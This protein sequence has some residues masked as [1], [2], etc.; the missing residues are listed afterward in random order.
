MHRSP[1]TLLQVISFFILLVHSI[2]DKKFWLIYNACSCIETNVVFHQSSL[3]HKD[4]P[5]FD[6]LI[7]SNAFLCNVLFL[8]WLEIFAFMF[9][10]IYLVLAGIDLFIFKLSILVF[11][12]NSLFWL[13]MSVVHT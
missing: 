8:S 1:L 2:Q 10:P 12:R 5:H 7:L 3:I 4:V 11:C 13:I 9:V 6:P